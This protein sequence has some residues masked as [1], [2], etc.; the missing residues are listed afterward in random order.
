MEGK[1]Y[2]D[3]VAGI[4]VVNTGHNQPQSKAAVL[5]H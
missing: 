5:A 1:R 4:A 2:I 3:F